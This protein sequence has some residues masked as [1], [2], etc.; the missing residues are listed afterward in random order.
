M[1]R[2]ASKNSTVKI[3][4]ASAVTV[5]ADT[6]EEQEVTSEESEPSPT[7]VAS[8]NNCEQY[9]TLVEQYDWDS[10]LMMAIMQA[11]SGCNPQS[12]NGLDNHGSCTGSFGLFQIGCIHA[13]EKLEPAS[14][15]AIAYRIYKSQGLRAWGAYTNGSY[16]KYLN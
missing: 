4:K 15:I 12:V 16:L 13:G 14:N 1:A 7:V 5:L 2:Y 11:E 9:R 6:D 8:D 3:T 10:R